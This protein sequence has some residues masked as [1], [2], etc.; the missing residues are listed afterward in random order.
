MGGEGQ[1]TDRVVKV[2]LVANATQLIAE[3]EKAA[4]KV[5]QLG[6][7]ADK[8]AQKRQA[9]TDLGRSAMLLGTAL[10]VGVGLAIAKFAE[11]DQAMSN[12]QAATQESAANMYLL[13]DAALEAGARTV[14]TA[15]E[16]A[17]AIEELGKNGLTTA[18]ILGGGLNAALS[19][20]SAG[21]LGVARAAEVAAL[22]MKQ[23]KLSGQELPHVADLL[24]AG[25]GKA[26]GDVDDMAQALAQGGLVA[27]STGLT[28]EETTGVLA[29]FAD[30]ALIGSD[31][32]TSLKTM[33]Q[34]LTPQSKEAADKMSEL[35]IS[36]YDAK[37][38]FIGAAAFA[39]NLRESL[40]RL[41]P[42]ERSAAEAII[43]GSDA[44]RAANVLFNEGAEGIQKYI[45]QTDDSGYAAKVAAD[46]LNNLAGDVEKLGGSFDTAL[47]KTG[48]GANQVLR[49][50]VQYTTFVVDGL[51]SIPGPALTTGLSIAGVAAAVLLVA[52]ATFTVIP[53]LAAMKVA[54]QELNIN[55]KGTALAVGLLGTAVSLAAVLVG[56]FV[57]SEQQK[58][59]NVDAFRDSID[60]A[61]GSV[62]DYTREL[63]KKR[64][65]DEGIYDA[66]K[67][68]GIG[69]DLVTDAAM[70]NK[71]A[72]KEV[73][74]ETVAW[75]AT[76]SFT[77]RVLGGASFALDK[78]TDGTRIITENIGAAKDGQ[79]LLNEA[80]S[81]GAIKAQ[82]LAAATDEMA[83]ASEKWRAEIADADGSFVTLNGALDAVTQKNHDAAQAAA[84][85]TSD[86]S[87][88]WETF[89]SDFSLTVDD[90]LSELQRMVDAQASW[91][92][93]MILLA[94][95]V[96]SDTLSELA[97]MGPEGAP[98][99]AELVNASD[100]ELSRMDD[101]FAQRAADATGAFASELEQA[102][103][104]VGLAG[105]ELG[106]KTAKEIAQ[107]LSD[108]TATVSEIM[109]EYKLRIE[110]LDPTVQVAVETA[111]AQQE[112]DNFLA[113]NANHNISITT[114]LGGRTPNLATGG[115]IRGPGSGTSDSIH[116]RLSNGEFV[117][118]ARQTALNR[119]I[120]ARI[121][122]GSGRLPGFAN[123]GYVDR[124]TASYAAGSGSTA[125]YVQNPFTGEYL[126]SQVGGQVQA[127]LSGR[128]T[129]D[130][131]TQLHGW[132]R[133][134]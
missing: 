11:F 64:L 29:A 33:L 26:A 81:E 69:I 129:G 80:E 60:K 131:L 50:M 16:A 95:R 8:L 37:G 44:V 75:Y 10:A 7:E 90:Y 30:N 87:D 120:L 99:V 98:L 14:F 119:D 15:T 46:R 116:A 1:L 77:E 63:V 85:A 52:G 35:G 13:R 93:N 67:K 130:Q 88:S 73:H 4:L 132:R 48:A 2:S 12:V 24:A 115:Y 125:I 27:H 83:K 92:S 6:S 114:G 38:N 36:A 57:A 101:L 21:Q 65:L 110:D 53:R 124:H 100:A 55:A 70:G 108:G 9:F 42:Q 56:A 133:P 25:A 43:F 104:V 103:A 74:D 68:A 96:S 39:G 72:I 22:S 31:A 20:A 121:N 59:A 126:L 41:T 127:G 54:M 49:D 19:L 51:G 45:D 58:A 78:L 134:V 117:I 113:Y 84:D 79:K 23:F 61:T 47:I 82:E 62:T 86:S 91:E 17:N 34:R 109:N 28:I 118:N 89:S 102:Q 105:R 66:A 94:G 5:R 3:T 76:M 97:K 122:S 123:G 107:K 128:D 40:M 71:G 112:L 18:E 106:A 32:G 111:G